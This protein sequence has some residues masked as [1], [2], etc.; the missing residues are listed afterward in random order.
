MKNNWIFI[1][2]FFISYSINSQEIL[3]QESYQ[4]TLNEGEKLEKILSPQQIY[5]N[6]AT[7]IGGKTRVYFPIEL[8]RNTLKWFYVITTTQGEDEGES[9]NVL[10][11]L[12]T[13]TFTGG[14][15]VIA[16]GMVAT[17]TIPSGSGGV[18]DCYLFDRQ[19]LDIF[20][21][22]GDNWGQSLYHS[23]EGTR[24]NFKSGLIMINNPSPQYVYIG[25]K[26]PSASTGVNVKIEA[27]AITMENADWYRPFNIDGS[28]KK[29]M[30]KILNTHFKYKYSQQISDEL[31]ICSLSKMMRE[32]RA[33][34][35]ISL[36]NYEESYKYY[37]NKTVESCENEYRKNHQNTNREKSD[38]YNKF[39]WEYY[40]K[41]DIPKAYE[42]YLKA[43]E[44]DSDNGIAI[45]NLALLLIFDNKS[46]EAKEKYI[47]AITCF[48]KDIIDGRKGMEDAYDKL[49]NL[50][51][52]GSN[53]KSFSERNQLNDIYAIRKIILQELEN[54]R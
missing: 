46:D 50:L 5:I 41:N 12:A 18:V 33:D 6:S 1:V 42:N 4:I 25:I 39:G 35:L 16:K 11:Q 44:I 9:L 19:N 51:D 29:A 36:F 20:T 37:F 48:K 32:K 10:G 15:S 22:K 45:A 30:E 34:E 43:I 27:I 49:T 52:F 13:A 2:L 8:P 7:K 21:S 17:V 26:N 53:R 31:T 28:L 23:I 40:T 54:M 14:A 24:G 47:E 3:N 38:I